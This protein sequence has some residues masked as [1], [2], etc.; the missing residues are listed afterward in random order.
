MLFNYIKL[1]EMIEGFFL[2][3]IYPGFKNQSMEVGLI[4]N[5]SFLQNMYLLWSIMLKASLNSWIWSWLNMANTLLVALW[6]LFLVV[7]LRV[8]VLR[9]DIF[10][11]F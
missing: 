7:P 9:E 1:A 4:Y 11:D 5:L 6:A 8:A 3:Q 10:I 2:Y